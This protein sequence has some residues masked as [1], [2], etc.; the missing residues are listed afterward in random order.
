MRRTTVSRIQLG[1][2]AVALAL[3][4]GVSMPTLG[5]LAFGMGDYPGGTLHAV[6][7]IQGEEGEAPSTYT[8]DV[9][10][11]E[12]LFRMTE[13]ISSAPTE[14]DEIG[15]GFGSNRAAGTAGVQ[16]DEDD[17]GNIDTSP[18]SALDDRNVEVQPGENYYL[19]DGARLIAGEV[20][21]YAGIQAVLCT[22][23]HP[24]YPNQVMYIALTSRLMSDLLLFPVY[25]WTEKD[26]VVI[27]T[28]ELIEFVHSS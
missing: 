2:I 3:S 22:Y 7:R 23:L 17:G 27:R 8:V 18:I 15:S 16:Y 19:P 9:L 21:E 14:K 6:W 5:E 11:E 25:M 12:D 13:R 24:G 20:V 28:I 1:A 4:I 26:G 10:P